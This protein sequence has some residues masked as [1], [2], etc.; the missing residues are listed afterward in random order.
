[1]RG[2]VLLAVLA[3]PV[4]LAGGCA[5]RPPTIA[6]VHLGHAITAAHDT[7][8]QVGYMTLAEE[9]A[10]AAL[11]S[12]EAALAETSLDGLK[13]RV[14]EVDQVTNRL[15]P[16]PLVGAVQ[17]A[18]SHIEYAALSEDASENVRA[19]QRQFAQGIEGVLTRG[20]L[21]ESYA[22]DVAAATSEE[23]A[24]ALAEEVH[25]L[26]R[27]NLHG[28]D[29]DGDGTI[30][31]DPAE[32]GVRQIRGDLDALIGREDP[33]YVTVDRW[34]LFNLIRLPSGEWIFARSR[35]RGTDAYQ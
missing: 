7:P 20:T 11:A 2:F 9:Q 4:G 10:Q 16:Y 24:R 27:A 30:G 6:H 26:A 19:G 15:R 23:E 25:S 14:A 17:E 34:Y 12:A 33:A 28:E 1:M 8:D 31:S 21:I 22:R 35:S 13:R 18:A 32:Y 29:V 3:V 5:H